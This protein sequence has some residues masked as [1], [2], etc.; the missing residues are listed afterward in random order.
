M[1]YTVLD[2]LLQCAETTNVHQVK[3]ITWCVYKD[4]MKNVTSVK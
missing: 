2:V 3:N 4:C 1:G